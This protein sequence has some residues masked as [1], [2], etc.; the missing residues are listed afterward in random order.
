[1]I[2]SGNLNIT[3]IIILSHKQEWYLG[4]LIIQVTFPKLYE[5]H[6]TFVDE[7]LTFVKEVAQQAMYAKI[8]IVFISKMKLKYEYT[9]K[10]FRRKDCQSIVWF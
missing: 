1:L 10:N 5:K 8:K 6:L 3:I 9:R 7:M 4:K 2:A